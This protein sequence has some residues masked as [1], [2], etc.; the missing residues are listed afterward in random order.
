MNKTLN[1]FVYF[2]TCLQILQI[3]SVANIASFLNSDCKF[4]NTLA[5]FTINNQ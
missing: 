3:I 1:Q 4:Y 5:N 2:T